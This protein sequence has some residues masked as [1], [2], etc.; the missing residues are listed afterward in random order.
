ML[1]QGVALVRERGIQSDLDLGPLVDPAAPFN[2]D[3]VL[4]QRLQHMFDAGAWVLMESAL[5]DLPGDLRWLFESGA[6]TLPQ[7]AALYRATG[8]TSASDIGAAI[9][10]GTLQAVTGLDEAAQKAIAS[11]LPQLRAAIPRI[12]LGRAIA[13]ADPVLEK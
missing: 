10:D 11:A 4:H 13:I 12:P 1:E 9:E 3:P 6:V 5:A 2:V 7:L 8:A